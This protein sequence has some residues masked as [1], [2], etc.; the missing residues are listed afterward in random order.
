MEPKLS[1]AKEAEKKRRQEERREK[2]EKRDKQMMNA[3]K[4]IAKRHPQK[5]QHSTKIE[6]HI[7]K[8]LNGDMNLSWQVSHSDVKHFRETKLEKIN[9]VWRERLKD[10]DAVALPTNNAATNATTAPPP[11]ETTNAK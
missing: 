11:P 9:G 5:L 4:L 6:E 7:Y 8:L 3:Y 2:E 1:P 10:S